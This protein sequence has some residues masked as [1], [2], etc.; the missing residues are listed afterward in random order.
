MKPFLGMFGLFL[1]IMPFLAP[2]S[3]AH[4]ILRSVGV[5]TVEVP[6]QQ[7]SAEW[8]YETCLTMQCVTDALAKLPP[9]KAHD[10]KLTTWGNVTYVVYRK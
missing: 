9:D 4:A 10:A 1:M 8:K 6:F 7:R 2:E 5:Q 3:W